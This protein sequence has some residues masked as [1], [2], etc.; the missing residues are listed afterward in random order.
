MQEKK[1]EI[2]ELFEVDL[3]STLFTPFRFSYD[4]E[5]MAAA[6]IMADEQVTE[7]LNREKL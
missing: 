2:L 5:F 6:D 4:E 1:N 7:I 3:D